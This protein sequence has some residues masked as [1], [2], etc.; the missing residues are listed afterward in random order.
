MTHEGGSM[1]TSESL[2][3]LRRENPRSQAGFAEAVE[4]QSSIARTHIVRESAPRVERRPPRRI[5]RVSV[6]GAA[7]AVV[8]AAASL[9]VGSLGGGPGVENA[10]A[11]VKRAAI[12][13][14]ASADRSGTAT[15]RITHGG[16]L[17]VGLTVRWHGDDVALARGYPQRSGKVGDELR[18]VDGMMYGLDPEEGGWVEL[19]PPS[20]IDPDSGTTPAEYLGAVRE[21]VGGTTLRRISAGMTGLTAQQL[22]DGSTVYSGKVGAGL[23]A[24]ETGFKEGH[25][26]R[27]F[28]FGYVAHD[29][30]ADPANLLDVEA[31]V[32]ADDIVRSIVVRWG[33]GTSAWVYSVSY[34]ALGA[35]AAPVAPENASS[36]LRDR[37]PPKPAQR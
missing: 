21:D 1:S 10:T 18:V 13:T 6:A 32:G 35:T 25:A 30:A 23:I 33:A 2:T 31:T 9:A 4:A 15:V 28:P 34:A 36:L 11:A 27:V 29:E 22:D 8:A 19:G 37:V 5:L 12:A 7:L 3:A 14:A 20:S 24:R 16:E 17:W 26:I